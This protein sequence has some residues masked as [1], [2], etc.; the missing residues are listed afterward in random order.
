LS[1]AKYW[2]NTCYHSALGKSPFEVLYGHLPTHFG[3][4]SPNQCTIPDLRN[5]LNSQ[6][7]VL[8]QVRMHLQRA[9]DQMKQQAD[10]GRSESV[11][12]GRPSVPEITAIL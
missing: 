9:Q 2:Y 7:E 10:K 1:L 4:D 12:S 3:L 11:F 8:Q 6:Q 5:L